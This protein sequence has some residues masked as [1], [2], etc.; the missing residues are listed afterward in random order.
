[1]RDT[2]AIVNVVR[3]AFGEQ[4]LDSLPTSVTGNASECLFARGF[5]SIARASVGS[6]G[7]IEFEDN[8]RG[9]K[10]ATIIARMTGGEQTGP[11]AV[12]TPA[13]FERVIKA[14][15]QGDFKSFNA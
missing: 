2:L 6:S 11:S 12:Q 4:P 10:A 14:F 7:H 8:E 9:R 15:D 1:M 5:G 13:V 3:A